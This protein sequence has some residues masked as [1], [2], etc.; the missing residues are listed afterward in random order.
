MVI[1][2]EEIFLSSEI[3][4]EITLERSDKNSSSREFD[5]LKN[6]LL[7][8][9]NSNEYLTKSLEYFLKTDLSGKMI[10]H[11]H[12]INFPGMEKPLL[13]H[14][15]V[16][17]FLTFYKNN[18]KKDDEVL[19]YLS[20]VLVSHQ[21][22]SD[23]KEL[24]KTYQTHSNLPL[25]LEI[26]LIITEI[27]PGPLPNAI[28]H[29]DEL[30]VLNIIFK[31]KFFEISETEKYLLY[32]KIIEGRNENLLGFVFHLFK[33]KRN[34]FRNIYPILEKLYPLYNILE[35]ID[36]KIFIETYSLSGNLIKRFLLL[37][38]IYSRKEI[39]E[40]INLEKKIY[41]KIKTKNKEPIDYQSNKQ[42]IFL[43]NKDLSI[44]SP[45]EL[46]L[47]LETPSMYKAINEYLIESIQANPYSY[48]LNLSQ[49]VVHFHKKDF[50][51]ALKYLENSGSM[52]WSSESLY[53][54]GICLFKCGYSEES[55]RIMK[56]LQ[57]TFPQNEE[58]KMYLND[59]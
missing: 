49:A 40:W 37:K 8:Y 36:Q 43:R 16:D 2:W 35:P 46:Y 18:F 25:I 14:S 15:I 27:L 50:F 58:I 9:V 30:D 13:F 51:Q 24:L 56:T 55:K 11:S 26:Y 53:I 31:Y 44:Y 34:G 10:S 38:K 21:R 45:F 54:K 47:A 57:A 33:N 22:T 32:D 20:K 42:E 39:F 23:L 41:G 48:I 52:R 19:I 6:N 28:L 29:G 5:T 12:K 59:F 7:D 4:S 3:I 1:E 17:D